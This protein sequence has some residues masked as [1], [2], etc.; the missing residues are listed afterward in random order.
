M[1]SLAAW[2]GISKAV[3]I[4]GR[5][6]AAMTPEAV[7]AK[8]AIA[9]FTESVPQ[10]LGQFIGPSLKIAG[11]I[12]QEAVTGALFGLGKVRGPDEDPVVN[13]LTGAAW[14]A[15]G[16]TGLE[17][18]GTIGKSYKVAQLVKLKDEIANVL[19]ESGTLSEEAAQ[20]QAARV[21]TNTIYKK[22]GIGEVSVGDI[23]EAQQTA[24]D[25]FEQIQKRKAAPPKTAP[26]APIDT[27]AVTE[28]PPAAAAPEAAP[29]PPQAVPVVPPQPVPAAQNI[30]E[31]L[32]A[33]ETQPITPAPT[34][35]PPV[36]AAPP[37]RY[38]F[39]ASGRRL[40]RQHRKHNYQKPRHHKK[41]F[42]KFLRTRQSRFKTR[43]KSTAK[44][45]LCRLAPGSQ[46]PLRKAKMF[47]QETPP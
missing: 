1:G 25:T 23:K 42:Q 17:V 44:R 33:Q 32:P 45:E 14:G 47:H 43:L 35:V 15:A 6:A 4:M 22:G 39:A 21:V 31:P 12:S 20:H 36:A 27:T 16:A 40:L 24:R 29:V 30:P 37:P 11:R 41:E 28:T 9:N 5:G 38:Q 26:E 2:G 10:A 3:G 8:A 46:S 19:Y 18:L 34:I 13:A 7:A